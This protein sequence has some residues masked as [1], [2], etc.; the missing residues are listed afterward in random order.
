M[1]TL[2]AGNLAYSITAM[3][4]EELFNSCGGTVKGIKL[5]RNKG[6]GFV[7]MSSESEVDILID[8]LKE[9]TIDGRKIILRKAK[10]SLN[11]S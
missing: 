3:Q 5:V 10:E 6:Y 9:S 11:V 7:K 1:D 2:Y 8:K 4:L